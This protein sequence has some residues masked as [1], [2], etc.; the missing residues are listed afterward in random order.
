ML[1]FLTE[2]RK[3]EISA[4]GSSEGSWRMYI[5]K[6]CKISEFSCCK[7]CLLILFFNEFFEVLSC[8]K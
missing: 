7:M 5:M 8:F 1:F 2:E 3:W 4:M 6:N